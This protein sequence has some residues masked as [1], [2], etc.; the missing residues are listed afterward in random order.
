MFGYQTTNH[1]TTAM[2]IPAA[3]RR[4]SREA[5]TAPAK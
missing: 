2:T 5:S 1:A 4:L 3:N